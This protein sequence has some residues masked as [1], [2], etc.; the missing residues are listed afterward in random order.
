MFFYDLR[1]G[2]SL[3]STPAAQTLVNRIC[4]SYLGAFIANLVFALIRHHCLGN[5][6]AKK[7][8]QRCIPAAIDY[9]CSQCGP[10]ISDSD[11]FVATACGFIG[12]E[13]IRR[14]AV[15]SS[16]TPLTLFVSCRT[17]GTAHIEDLS[18]IPQLIAVQLGHT[19][20]IANCSAASRGKA[21]LAGILS[22]SLKDKQL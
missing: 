6:K 4:C 10:D 13:L 2:S 12:I 5:E 17:I 20:M 1:N 15:T 16:L 19:L 14:F 3:L 8:L 11:E 7:L 9:Y 22:A 21:G 18:S